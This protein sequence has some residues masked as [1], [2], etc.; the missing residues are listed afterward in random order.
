MLKIFYLNAVCIS[1]A[2]IF[3]SPLIY[4]LIYFL[5][6][7]QKCLCCFSF[8]LIAH[9]W[10]LKQIYSFNVQK[11]F[12]GH[13]ICGKWCLRQGHEAIFF[14]KLFMRLIFPSKSA[15]TSTVLYCKRTSLNFSLKQTE[16]TRRKMHCHYASIALS[17]KAHLGLVSLY[18]L[19]F[20]GNWNRAMLFS[21][22]IWRLSQLSLQ[23]TLSPGIESAVW[24]QAVEGYPGGVTALQWHLRRQ[25]SAVHWLF[26]SWMSLHS[27][28]TNQSTGPLQITERSVTHTFQPI[29]QGMNYCRLTDFS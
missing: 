7:E 9:I 2:L 18:A 26:S 12:G 29:D 22:L 14:F 28:K 23:H 1:I 3:Y 8:I 17:S 4:L 24:W 20:S 5:L 10:Y 15:K 25:S 21:F 6:I 19:S 27:P 11:G 16:K 13:C